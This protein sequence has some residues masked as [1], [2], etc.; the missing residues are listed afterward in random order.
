MY[1]KIDIQIS[2]AITLGRLERRN[3][4]DC[5]FDFIKKEVPL[6]R[7]YQVDLKS[8]RWVKFQCFGCGKIT[9]VRAIDV[10]DKFGATWIILDLLDLDRAI[11][12][13]PKPVSWLPVD[14]NKILPKQGLPGGAKLL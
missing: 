9:H 10:W 1:R 5:G 3:V 13:M 8:V 14:N 12:F 2:P 4:C 11:A 7:E 6:G